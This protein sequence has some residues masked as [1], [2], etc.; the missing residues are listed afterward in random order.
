MPEA[1]RWQ[2]S[3]YSGG[4]ADTNC[5]EIAATPTTLHLRESDD[6]A[7]LLTPAPTALNTML[8]ALKGR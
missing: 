4:D 5:L 2:K 6:P 1:L 3:S 7:T 8:I